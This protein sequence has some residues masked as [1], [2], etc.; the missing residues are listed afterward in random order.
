IERSK[1]IDALNGIRGVRAFPS[2]TNFVLFQVNRDSTSVY[3]ALLERGIIIREVGSVLKFR[4][5]LRVTVAP[6][7]MMNRFITML[8]EVLDEDA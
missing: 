7:P 4:N 8:R 1:L 5:C 6:D 3:R 2:E